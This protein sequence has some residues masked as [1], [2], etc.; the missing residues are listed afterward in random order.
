MTLGKNTVELAKIAVMFLSLS[1]LTVSGLSL[2]MA[3]SV[4]APTDEVI[5]GACDGRQRHFVSFLIL[6]LIGIG[7]YLAFAN[8]VCNQFVFLYEGCR[9][10]LSPSM[11]SMVVVSE[12]VRSPLQPMNLSS[13]AAVSSTCS[14]HT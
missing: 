5:I 7:H 2:P 3:V 6:L 10:A 9:D 12:P 11:V 13:G 14:L 1:M 8:H 4:T